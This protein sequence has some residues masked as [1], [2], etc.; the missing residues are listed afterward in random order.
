MSNSDASKAAGT[1]MIIVLVAIATG[2][3]MILSVTKTLTAEAIKVSDTKELLGAISEILPPFSNAID[4]D[5][6]ALETEEGSVDSYP[7]RD[8]QGKLVGVAVYGVSHKAYGGDIKVIVGVLADGSI[9]GIRILE[10]KETPGLGSRA[11]EPEFLSQFNGN[12]RTGEFVW[13]VKKDGGSV[14]AISGATISSRAVT[15]A[16]DNALENFEKVKA[17]LQ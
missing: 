12:G 2:S 14:D 5:R 6:I 15:E 17:E 8:A 16:V 9:N 1:K 3:A 13:K 7:A 4:K 10:H 11:A